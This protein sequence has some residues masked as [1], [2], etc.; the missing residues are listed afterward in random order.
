MKKKRFG[1]SKWERGRECVLQ[2]RKIF[3]F[4]E[5]AGIGESLL[6]KKPKTR[7]GNLEK[8]RRIRGET[9]SLP[10]LTGEVSKK[11]VSLWRR[12]GQKRN[13]DLRNQKGGRSPGR[14]KNGDVYLSGKKKKGRG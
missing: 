5:K 7:Q 10:L 8:D 13:S 9:L 2:K 14:E 12:R 4:I 1:A 11:I 6:L 3:I